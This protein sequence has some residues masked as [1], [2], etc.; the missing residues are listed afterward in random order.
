M[1]RIGTCKSMCARSRRRATAARAPLS[2]IGGL[3]VFTKAIED[4]LLAREIDIA[5]HS[6]KDLPPQL[7]DGLVLG[8]VPERG[9]ARDALVARDGRTLADAAVGRAHRHRQRAPGGA[10]PG[11]ARGRRAGRHPRQRRHAHPQGRGG[12]STTRAVLAMAGLERLGLA[13]KATQVFSVDEMMPAVGQG[14]LAVEVRADDAE[15][16]ALVRAIDHAETRAAVMAERAFLERLGAGC[17][18]PSGHATVTEDGRHW[19]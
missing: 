8:A 5:V 2:E 12:R 17:R 19:S 10:A 13:H 4:A 1:R 18:C 14:A 7:A 3:G 15:A 16:L 6:L 9:D 11:A